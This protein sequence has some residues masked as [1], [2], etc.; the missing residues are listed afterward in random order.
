MNTSSVRKVFLVPRKS[1]NL[2]SFWVTMQ[3]NFQHI[4][5]LSVF[6]SF[7]CVCVCGVFVCV[8]MCSCVCVWGRPLYHIAFCSSLRPIQDCIN[9]RCLWMCL[10]THFLTFLSLHGRCSG[11]RGNISIRVLKLAV[12]LKRQHFFKS[13]VL[14]Y[15]FFI[16]T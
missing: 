15:T 5:K 16:K 8:C 14:I 13:I 7:I 10:N 4:S 9:V 11:W 3:F 6:L 12:D 1:T 2:Q